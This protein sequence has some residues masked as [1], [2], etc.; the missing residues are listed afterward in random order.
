MYMYI[1]YGDV[2]VYHKILNGTC[3]LHGLLHIVLI[4]LIHLF[5]NA[6]LTFITQ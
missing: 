2:H 4:I 3:T 1:N 5:M 6:G